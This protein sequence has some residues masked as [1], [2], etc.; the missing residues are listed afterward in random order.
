MSTPLN[1]TS[2]LVGSMRRRMLRPAVGFPRPDFPTRP[3]T[4]PGLMAKETYSTAFTLATTRE[5]IPPRIGKYLRRLLTSRR[6]L[7]SVLSVL[8]A[9]AGLVVMLAPLAAGRSHPTVRSA[10]CGRHRCLPAGAPQP[11]TYPAQTCSAGGRRSPRAGRAGWVRCREWL[12]ASP[13]EWQRDR[14]AESSS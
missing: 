12:R 9:S 6:F 14:P 3:T 2:P 8:T 10:P 13:D 4:S 5:K 1:F 11:C 7:L